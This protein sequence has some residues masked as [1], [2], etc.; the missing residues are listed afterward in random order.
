MMSGL[1]DKIFRKQ[2][3]QRA[4]RDES[5]DIKLFIHP[6]FPFT[7]PSSVLGSVYALV[8]I[9]ICLLFALSCSN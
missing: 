9:D 2:M 3:K 4:G 5:Q 6:V 8:L 7:S 1:I